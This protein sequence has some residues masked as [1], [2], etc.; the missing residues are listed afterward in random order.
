MKTSTAL[1]N[2]TLDETLELMED[3]VGVAFDSETYYEEAR[4]ID[5]HLCYDPSDDRYTMTKLSDTDLFKKTY[6]YIKIAE[7]DMSNIDTDS[8]QEAIDEYN[9]KVSA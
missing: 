6:G 9:E 1:R 8:F 2:I 5:R 4:G 7:F 3:S